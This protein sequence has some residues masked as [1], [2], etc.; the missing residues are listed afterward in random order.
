MDVARDDV[1][2]G[3][4]AS[5]RHRFTYGDGKPIMYSNW[6]KDQPI[7][8]SPYLS[9]NAFDCLS[10]IT[11]FQTVAFSNYERK[12]HLMKYNRQKIKW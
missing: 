8:T 7:F 10:R 6:A 2:T 3:L 5:F 9:V 12:L 4:H 1:W 11:I